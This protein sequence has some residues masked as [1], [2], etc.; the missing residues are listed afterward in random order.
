MNEGLIIKVTGNIYTVRDIS[1]ETIPCVIK[2][3]LR[4]K[5]FKST[6]PIAVGDKVLYSKVSGDSKGIIHQILDR[7]NYIIRKATKLS[8]QYH[9]I[10]SNVDQAILVVTLIE[11]LTTFEFI[12]RY[13][14][15]CEAFRIPAIIVIN[16]VDLYEG[17]WHQKFKDLKEIYTSAG[18]ICIETSIVNGINLSAFKD[19]LQNKVS[20]LNGH[21]GVGKSSLIKAIAPQLDIKIGEISQYHR[22]GLHTTSYSQM[23]EIFKHTFIIDTPGIKGFG[24]ID[25]EKN[26]LYHFFPEIF[27]TSK[28]CKFHNCTHIHE[29]GCAVIEAVKHD[30]IA[31]SRYNSYLNIYFDE[32]EKYRSPF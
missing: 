13:L 26:E 32:N 6:N 12:D 18:Y 27:K 5:G 2:G 4:V 20:V 29:P 8:K 21:S 7:K 3:N 9:I 28:S 31:F 17:Q 11:P 15:S 16:K 10:A 14:V 25:I 24:L 23:Y 1:G 19:I 30:K 22:A